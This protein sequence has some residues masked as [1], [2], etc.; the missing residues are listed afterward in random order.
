MSSKKNKKGNSSGGSRLFSASPSPSPSPS[1]LPGTGTGAANARGRSG[2]PLSDDDES[3]SVHTPNRRQPAGAHSEDEHLA[4]SQE[5]TWHRR[6]RD[7]CRE[8]LRTLRA[9]ELVV[10]EDLAKAV[11]AVCTSSGS[12]DDALKLSP[13]SLIKHSSIA[14]ALEDLHS[15]VQDLQHL[16]PR[17][18]KLSHKLRH[19][20]LSAQRILTEALD[21]RGVEFVSAPHLST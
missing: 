4:R 21:A 1:P 13:S 8:H 17:L 3:A 9:W 5:T 20:S 2:T 11:A 10:Q 12:L 16:L 6:A 18:S 14:S 19:T 7:L 15:D